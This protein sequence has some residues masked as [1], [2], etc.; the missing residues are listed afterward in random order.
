MTLIG[1]HIVLPGHPR[2]RVSLTALLIAAGLL[3]GCGGSDLVLPGGG[4]EPVSIRVIQGD[5][6]SGQMGDLVPVVVEVTDADG[7]PIEGASVAFDLTSA[8]PGAAIA[9]PVA[10]TDAVGRAQAQMLLGTKAGLQTGAAQ[11]VIESATAP[12]ASFSVIVLPET[13][14]NQAPRADFDPRCQDLGCEFSDR[15]SDQDGSVTGWDWNFGDGGSSSVR[16]PA[17]T[18]QAA[19][20]YTVTL[21]VTDDDGATDVAQRNVSVS[22]PEPPPNEAPQADFEVH[23]FGLT[24]NL[25]DKSKDDDGSIVGWLWDFGDGSTSTEQNPVH[26]YQDSGHYQVTLT[27]TDDGGAV[28]SKTRNA[29]PKDH[30]D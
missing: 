18:Y 11:V 2:A 9:P 7:G 5:G 21:T 20:T 3:S 10:I 14:G 24:C 30:R 29:D 27:V 26:Q 13:P 17:H 1:S 28:G 22:A 6:E 12:K 19:G 25:E 16:E 15:S 23:C 8:G 4:G